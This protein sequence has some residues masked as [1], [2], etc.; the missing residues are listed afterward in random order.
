MALQEVQKKVLERTGQQLVLTGGPVLAHQWPPKPGPPIEASLRVL[1]MK[2]ISTEVG[3]AM[4]PEY[5][6][7]ILGATSKFSFCLISL[8]GSFAL[9]GLRA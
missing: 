8:G 1:F 6:I 9:S 7:S 3:E 2:V 5:S 4:S